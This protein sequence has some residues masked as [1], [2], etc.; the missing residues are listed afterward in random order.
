MRD[1][2]LLIDALGKAANPV[3]RPASAARRALAWSPICLLAG[4]MATATLHPSWSR[5]G[6]DGLFG[7]VSAATCLAAG[8]LLLIAALE[9]S[10]PGRRSRA[11]PLS[12][13][14]ILAWAVAG[15][16][17]LATAGWPLGRLG[18]GVYCFKFVACASAPM[19]VLVA[20]ALRRTYSVRPRRTMLL[21]AVG[22]CFL[23]FALLAF[24]H[25]G[26]LR[27]YDFSM[28]LAA[29]ALVIPISTAAGWRFVSI[30]RGGVIAGRPRQT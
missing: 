23:A 16:V 8:V 24:C 1:H 9:L 10:I 30:P 17:D 12:A 20:L 3:R 4:W 13:L 11:L 19:A 6:V 21:G 26:R 27:L 18:E 25:H 2:E 29:A 15:A 22:T 28:H 7:L 5:L 14:C